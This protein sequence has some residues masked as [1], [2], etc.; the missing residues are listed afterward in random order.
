MLA[1]DFC[2]NKEFVLLE[3]PMRRIMSFNCSNFKVTHWSLSDVLELRR[4]WGKIGA[5]TTYS[6]DR[7]MGIRS[8]NVFFVIDISA[9]SLGKDG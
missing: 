9:L 1:R 3:K 7:F 4:H 6:S 8:D 5:I 2:L